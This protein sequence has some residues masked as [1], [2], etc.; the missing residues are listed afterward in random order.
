ML[1]GN[2]KSTVSSRKSNLD[3]FKSPG[4]LSD[5]SLTFWFRDGAWTREVE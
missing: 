2:V 5:L 3:F 4:G 1:K